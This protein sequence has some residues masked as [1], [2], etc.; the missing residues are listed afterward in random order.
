[1]LLSTIVV[2]A[3]FMLLNPILRDDPVGGVVRMFEHRFE[4]SEW[5]SLHFDS[6][7][8]FSLQDRFLAIYRNLF[9]SNGTNFG[10]I[11]FSIFAVDVWSEYKKILVKNTHSYT[12]ALVGVLIVV[13]MLFY[14]VIDW[15]RY[16]IPLVI[17]VINYQICG[18]QY[19]IL[20]T[21]N[22]LFSKCVK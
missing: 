17:F 4:I 9:L 10:V 16:Y 21:K 22:R 6:V 8:L 1:M 14:L 20:L 12:W 2:V 19:L 5:Q 7:G 15:S 3:V 13:A 18:V 11:M